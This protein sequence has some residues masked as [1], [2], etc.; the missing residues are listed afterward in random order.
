MRIVFFGT[1]ELGIPSLKAL[2]RYK[3]IISSVVTQPQRQRG[4]G[5]KVLPHSAEMAA[6]D[7][8]LPVLQFDNVNSQKSVELIKG[9]DADLFIVVAFG[10]ILGEP[11]LR[12]PRL[13]ALNIHASLL[14][15]YRGAAPIQW[16][17]I[18]G[19]EKTGVTIM[20]MNQYLD[21]GDIMLQK[22]LAITD[23]DDAATLSEK[24]SQVGAELLIEALKNIEQGTVQFMAQERSLVSSAPKL[25]KQD[26]RIDWLKDAVSIRNLIRGCYPWPSAYTYLD[27]K[28]LKILKAEAV[29][30][31][32]KEIAG[33][34]IQADKETIKVACGK[35]ALLITHL[36]IEGKRPLSTEEFLRGCP[37]DKGIL[38]G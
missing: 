2:V 4:R 36:Q 20:R 3:H 10:Q 21:Q 15:K 34:I 25:K 30:D 17:L 37:L 29:D 27:K 12:L 32:P 22:G 18:N 1:S 14:P 5:L 9:F 23:D 6:K 19:D 26:G 38:L 7:L 13:Y 16:A 8:G 28:L 33:S 11:L 31:R 35:G 24:L